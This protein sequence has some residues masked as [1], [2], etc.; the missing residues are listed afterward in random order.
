MDGKAIKKRICL[1]GT[2]ADPPTGRGGHVGIVSYLASLRSTDV[3]FV[4]VVDD[5][6]DDGGDNDDCQNDDGNGDKTNGRILSPPSAPPLFDEVWVLPVY[7]HVYKSK[8]ERMAPYEDRL[9]MCRLAFENEN[10]LAANSAKGE[11]CAMVRVSTVERDLFFSSRSCEVREEGLKLEPPCTAD[12][13]EF[14]LSQKRVVEDG[15]DNIRSSVLPS[16][17]EYTLA[18][19]YDS[20]QDLLCGKWRRSDDVVSLVNGRFVVLPRPKSVEQ[21]EGEE[22]VKVG[23]M[24]RVSQSLT[25]EL[26]L[27]SLHGTGSNDGFVAS[28]V[29]STFARKVLEH[30][31]RSVLSTESILAKSMPLMSS[32]VMFTAGYLMNPEV[33]AYAKERC[34]YNPR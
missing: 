21:L 5:A 11:A 25:S 13:L 17:V 33:E 18:L 28:V 23:G 14:L 7:S 20:H 32:P 34:L 31:I 26:S 29:S 27:S 22:K 12:L 3:N 1:F 16:N 4:G 2:S 24:D 30:N 10:I 9:A 19:G 8:R 15:G 6:N